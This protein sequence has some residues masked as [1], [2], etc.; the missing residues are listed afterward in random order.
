MKKALIHEWLVV[1]AGAEKVV[2]SITNIW[3][4]FD[5][6]S[7]IDHLDDKDRNIILKG[8]KATTSLI[9]KLPFSKSKYRSYL[10]LFPFAIEQFDL[11]EYD[12]V[13]TSAYA[14]ANGVL[15]NSDQLHISY[16]HTPIRYAWSL[17]HQYLEE[18]KL[19]KGLKGLIAKHYLHKIRQWDYI[20][21]QKVDH[22]IAN[23]HYIRKR[24][25]KVYGKDADVIYPPVDVNKFTL[26]EQKE[27]FYFTASR[28]VP[29]K[30]IDIIVKAFTQMPNKKLIVVGSGPELKK[31]KSIATNNIELLGY[32]PDEV[33]V[34]YMKR[35][36]A[37]IFPALE[38]FGIMPVEAQACGTPVLS[39]DR[40]GSA[41]TVIDGKT[42]MHFH[43]QLP[44]DIIETVNKFEK[45]I[46]V[47]DP[48]VIRKNAERFS[49]ERFE[50]EFENYINEKYNDFINSERVK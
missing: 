18:S 4:D 21:S 14:V 25:M 48:K 28:L 46:N 2:E 31:M 50:L 39:L 47:F 8:K 45:N 7:L 20:A 16:C 22:F 29:Y 1:H 27:D 38:D 49:T 35:A 37:F 19:N 17:Y 42:G 9:Q 11:R 13:L 12:V 24:I 26:H 6:F 33:L 44:E 36:K 32:Q 23:S 15:T 10:P 43:N 5:I 30:K 34:D 40:G 41:E 3:D